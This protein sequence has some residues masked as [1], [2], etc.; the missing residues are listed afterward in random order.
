MRWPDDE[1]P[2][3][4]EQPAGAFVALQPV[5]NPWQRRFG[6]AAARIW[7]SLYGTNRVIASAHPPDLKGDK[8]RHRRHLSPPRALRA[9]RLH[10]CWTFEP[11]FPLY[12]WE[13]RARTTNHSFQVSAPRKQRERR[14][15]V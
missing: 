9:L 5:S 11:L 8:G 4:D 14:Q 7:E 1:S 12:V 10:L 2:Q 6:R 13:A 15:L 3:K